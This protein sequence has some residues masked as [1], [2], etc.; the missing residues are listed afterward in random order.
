MR[1]WEN[2]PEVG[3]GT[4]HLFADVSCARSSSTR[5]CDEVVC[6]GG[7][8][9]LFNQQKNARIAVAIISQEKL[10]SRMLTQVIL[11]LANGC[12]KEFHIDDKSNARA[13][14]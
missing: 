5:G 9:R 11:L 8:W 7:Q 6:N 10:K 14:F 4:V 3:Y 13:H 2:R 1:L 12:G